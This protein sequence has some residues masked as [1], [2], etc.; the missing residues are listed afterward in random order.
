MNPSL[1]F[2]LVTD[3]LCW[4][5]YKN[6][7]GL[8]FANSINKHCELQKHLLQSADSFI[9]FCE[10]L[11]LDMYSCTLSCTPSLF[12]FQLYYCLYGTYI[13]KVTPLLSGCGALPKHS[14]WYHK[15]RHLSRPSVCPLPSSAAQAPSSLPTGCLLSSSPPGAPTTSPTFSSSLNCSWLFMSTITSDSSE[16]YAAANSSGD[17]AA[18]MADAV[19]PYA[20]IPVKSHVPMTLDL[21]SSN[22]SKWSS[23]FKAMC[24]K[25]GLMGLIDGTPPPNSI[26]AAW[27]QADC[28]VHSWLYGSVSD[29][30]L[31]FT[32]ED[33]QTARQLWVA[34]ETHF[35]ASQAPRAIFLSHEFHSM[36][37]GDL[38]VEEYGKKM[39]RVADALRA[40]GQLVANSTLILNLLH[41]VDPRYSTTGDFIAATPNITFAAALDQLALKELRLANEAKVAASLPLLPPHHP[42]VVPTAALHL[43][44]PVPSRSRAG[45]RKVAASGTPA[46][47]GAA[48]AASSRAGAAVG[49]QQQGWG[50]G[51][52]QQQ[53]RG[54][55][56]CFN[57]WTTQQGGQ[58]GG[59]SGGQN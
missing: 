22:Y 32:M 19:S 10:S 5:L 12:G 44:H 41:G 43:R 59:S 49:G 20:T 38:S 29:S 9:G 4:K 57:P 13:W 48:V 51:G 25:F 18:A 16:E 30:V 50:G 23:F 21:R 39:K 1:F 37:Q 35:Q 45:A 58:A 36:T 8:A 14:I 40:V 3:I 52:G 54:P 2:C 27:R 53:P 28:C 34:I 17:S 15:S 46:V 6:T 11:L 7:F 33:E 31:D 26:D 56:I 24:G 47:V 42:A 55:W